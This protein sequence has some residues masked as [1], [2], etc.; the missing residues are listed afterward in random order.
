MKK[1]K[2][3]SEEFLKGHYEKT[4]KKKLMDFVFTLFIK[5]DSFGVLY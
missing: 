2:E 3:I 5:E 4:I 1:A